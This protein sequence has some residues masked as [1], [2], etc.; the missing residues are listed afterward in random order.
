MRNAQRTLFQHGRSGLDAVAFAH[1]PR[2][3]P[4]KAASFSTGWRGPITRVGRASL[5]ALVPCPRCSEGV[6]GG[7]LGARMEAAAQG[8]IDAIWKALGDPT[9]RAI[10]DRLREGRAT[11]GEVVNAF[12]ELSRFAVMKHLGVLEGVGLVVTRKEGRRKWNY[13]NA[14]PLRRVYERWV[15][16]YE[17]R[18][19]GSLVGLQRL[20]EGQGDTQMPVADIAL[21]ARVVQTEIVI[22]APRGKVFDAFF[23]DAHD[24]FYES[25]QSKLRTRTVFERELGG[26]FYLQTEREDGEVDLNMLGF[27]TMIKPGRK[28]RFRGDCTIPSAFVAN[29]T[30]TFEDADGGT[31]VAIEHRMAGEFD[32]DLPAGFEE[33]WQDGLQKLRALV[34]SRV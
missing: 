6:L 20:V 31:R 30:I 24:W 8:E 11:T 29:M 17:D 34:E 18:W 33:G 28:V 25:E 32:A 19:A 15:S 2:H 23:A 5:A 7:V 21:S 9:R 10:L 14:V 22:A 4:V 26:R 27:V 1:G 3:G 12:P 16:R 13:L